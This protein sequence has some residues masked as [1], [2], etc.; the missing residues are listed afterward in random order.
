MTEIPAGLECLFEKWTREGIKSRY[1]FCCIEHF[2]LARLNIQ[3]W[4]TQEAHPID[5]RRMC[6]RCAVALQKRWLNRGNKK[7]SAVPAVVESGQ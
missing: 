3:P 6:S 5:G 4:H 2:I 1:P 7:T